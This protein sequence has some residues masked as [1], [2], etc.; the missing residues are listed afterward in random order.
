MQ[1]TQSS[2]LCTVPYCNYTETACESDWCAE[3]AHVGIRMYFEQLTQEV[4]PKNE[5]T[6]YGWTV[7]DTAQR[8]YIYIIFSL[9]AFSYFISSFWYAMSESIWRKVWLFWARHTSV[10]NFII[11]MCA[12]IQYEGNVRSHKQLNPDQCDSVISPVWKRD[13]FPH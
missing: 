12:R 6:L 4:R 10:I 11:N 8:I 2:T 7:V 5:T 3:C 9:G 13:R 1:T